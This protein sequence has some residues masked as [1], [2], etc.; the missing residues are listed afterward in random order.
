MIFHGVRDWDVSSRSQPSEDAFLPAPLFFRSGL[1]LHGSGVICQSAAFSVSFRDDEV[2]G[3]GI[4]REVLVS[5]GGGACS[6]H[7]RLPLDGYEPAVDGIAHG[8]EILCVHVDG[9]AGLEFYGNAVEHG[10]EVSGHGH[11]LIVREDSVEGGGEFPAH[12]SGGSGEGSGGS[13]E[14]V[15]DLRDRDVSPGDLGQGLGHLLGDERIISCRRGREHRAEG[16]RIRLRF[17]VDRMFGRT[18]FCQPADY[19]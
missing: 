8:E 3:L 14:Y 19:T 11:G 15:E 18:E 16:G 13:G 5:T 12:V 4:D 2:G 6:R 1:P 9:V 7:L 17:H 10:F